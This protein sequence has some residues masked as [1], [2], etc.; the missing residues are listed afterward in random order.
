MPVLKYDFLDS[1]NFT[2]DSE[3][4]EFVSG[5]GV[6]LSLREA[7]LTF[8]ESFDSSTGFTF[9]SSLIEF[10]GG[11][12][13]QKNRTPASSVMAAKYETTANLNWRN[14]G[15]SLS[16][17]LNG[18]PTISGGRLICTGSQGVS[19]TRT[20]SA[21]E[22]FKIKYTPN[23]TGAPPA[24][25][26]IVSSTGGGVLD[27]FLLT[28]SPS[29][30]TFRITLNNSSGAVVVATATTIGGAS[31]VAG[32]TYELE[33]SINSTAGT[34]R[35]FINGVAN[36]TLSPGAWARGGVSRS[37]YVG[38]DNTAIYNR[39]E[40]SFD[41]FIHFSNEQHTSGY[42]PGYTLVDTL[43]G[44]T[45]PTLPV[46]NHV[47]VG[48]IVSL[49]SLTVTETDSPR[50]TIALDGGS[51]QYFN[52]SAWANSDSSYAQA[53]SRVDFN[54]N[55]AS[56]SGQSGALSV[57]LQVAFTNT[58][59][60]GSVDALTLSHQ[61]HDGYYTDN[62]TVTPKTKFDADEI[63]SVTELSTIASGSLD[64]V[65]YILAVDNVKYYH[66][67]INW[68][69]S[70]GTYAQSNTEV[71]VNTN[72]TSLLGTALRGEICPVIFLH[73]DDG[74]TRPVLTSFEIDFS[75][76]GGDAVDL[77]T[78]TLFGYTRDILDNIV[79]GVTVSASL[80]YS[81]ELEDR[82][83]GTGP[84]ATLSD[85]EGY[86]ELNLPRRP[87]GVLV[88][89]LSFSGENLDYSDIVRIPDQDSVAYGDA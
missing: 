25:I 60:Q 79:E 31:L 36:G 23:Y 40:A 16:G 20:S 15:G 17:T 53:N 28:H 32:T 78:C 86:W 35:L 24:N 75:F 73:S 7:A 80:P 51:Q 69:T 45:T 70:D 74:Q 52:G 57:T 34:V 43:Y 56:L 66:D 82:L 48:S 89:N 29:G 27:R 2:F 26:N 11:V 14:D 30:D 38:A 4:I 19:Y 22:T 65:K 18:S 46:F 71:E 49:T 64:L 21:I 39:A 59:T 68:T 77:S 50:Y 10:A 63:N 62:P 6:T 37:Y 5:G 84:A 87:D 61:G 76:F 83:L 42:T 54:A 1:A 12:M 88:F 44:A 13:R 3:R 81:V 58:N 72:A 47:G 41:D 85:S 8:T 55:I 9:D 67:G 33:V